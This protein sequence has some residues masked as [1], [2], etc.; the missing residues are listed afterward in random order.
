ME[1]NWI[2]I[3]PYLESGANNKKD[4]KCKISFNEIVSVIIDEDDIDYLVE[5][6][7]IFKENKFTLMSVEKVK[8]LLEVIYLGE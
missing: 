3:S 4:I 8:E 5:K 7:K 6:L 1:E 2:K